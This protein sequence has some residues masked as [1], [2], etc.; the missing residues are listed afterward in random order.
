MGSR[1]VYFIGDTK[2]ADTISF[3]VPNHPTQELL[4]F[5]KPFNGNG[6][7]LSIEVE[8]VDLYF[9]ELKNDRN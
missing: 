5:R 1:L 3:L 8:N 4:N 6:I 9:E 7:Y 2:E